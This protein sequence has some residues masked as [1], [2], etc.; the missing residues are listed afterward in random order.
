MRMIEPEPS[1]A[2]AAIIAFARDTGGA[3]S[4]EYAFIAGFLSIA[5]AAGVAATG[6]SVKALFDSV[7]DAFP[8]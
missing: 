2:R 7:V 3:T 8:D 1:G 5:I 4:I 6:E